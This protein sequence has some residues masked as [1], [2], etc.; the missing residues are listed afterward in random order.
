[1]FSRDELRREYAQEARQD[2][3]ADAPLGE[4]LR[5]PRLE[6]LGAYVRRLQPRAP[7][8]F[9]GEGSLAVRDD[10]GKLRVRQPAARRGVYER[11]EVRAPARDQHRRPHHSST[12][13]SPL[14]TSPQ[15]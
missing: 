9:E 5:E 14:S 15:T 3:Q 12:P 10:E 4:Q 7:R 2:D 1:M 13:P 8:A 11:L 6:A